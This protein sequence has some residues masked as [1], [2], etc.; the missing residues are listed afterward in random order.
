MKNTFPPD[1]KKQTAKI[2]LLGIGLQSIDFLFKCQ[3][4]FEEVNVVLFEKSELGPF[5]LEALLMARDKNLLSTP[6]KNSTFQI[7]NI[8]FTFIP[9]SIKSIDKE[10]RVIYHKRGKQRY[11][12]LLIEEAQVFKIFSNSDQSLTALLS[13]S[14]KADYKVD[15]KNVV[16]IE[17]HD[18]FAISIA[19]R[20]LHFGIVPVIICNA[21]RLTSKELPEE[22]AWL[23]GKYLKYI[24]VESIFDV[25]LNFNSLI[26]HK[27]FLEIKT[28]K[29]K[30]LHAHSIISASVG[31]NSNGSMANSNGIILDYFG[32]CSTDTLDVSKF[33]ALLN[34]PFDERAINK[35]KRHYKM[36]GTWPCSQC[37]FNEL[38]WKSYGE[39][40]PNCGQNTHNFYWEHPGGEVSF[41]MQYGKS[42]LL[43][44]GLSFLG[45]P[46][47]I[48]F[49]EVMLEA[50]CNAHEFI[51]RMNE[52]LA[53]SNQVTDVY[54]LIK[55]SFGVEF[56]DEIKKAR[57]PFYKRI[58]KKWFK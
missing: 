55:K 26:S 29:N 8:T 51:E 53:N 2:V 38:E 16:V 34:E 28:S 14:Y 44:K 21:S 32:S 20:L 5:L 47:K 13:E 48:G 19:I 58:L 36:N 35:N 24:G 15:K 33:A 37:F 25:H 18:L 27:D 22:E 23:I 7:E 1:C 50:K 46:F 10:E 54:P 11:D 42:D 49:I 30:T 52:G 31:F 41:R 12:Y 39:I 45:I 3:S 43:I 6:D 4:K 40:S 9:S 56:K 57:D 17:G